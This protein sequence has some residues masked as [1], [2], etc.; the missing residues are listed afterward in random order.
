[1]CL[2]AVEVAPHDCD[3]QP[4]KLERSLCWR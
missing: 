3:S 2:N 4:I 1:M